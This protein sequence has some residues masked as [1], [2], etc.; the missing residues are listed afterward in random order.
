MAQ[1][2]WHDRLLPTEKQ[3][4]SNPTLCDCFCKHTS[5]KTR[6]VFTLKISE[7]IDT[8]LLAELGSGGGSV[9]RAGSLPIPKIRGS[10]P[11][12]V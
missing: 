9:V 1:C 11:V 8:K 4:G 12:I 5:T 6:L 7:F 3:S 2:L 10:N